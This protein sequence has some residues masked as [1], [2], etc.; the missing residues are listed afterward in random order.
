[1]RKPF[2]AGN[3][4]M[5]TDLKTAAALSEELA[6]GLTGISKVD[7]AICPPFTNLYY[8]KEIIGGSSVKLGA[9]NIFWENSG[10][11]T[12]EISPDMLVA[13]G[14]EYVIIG[15]SERRKYFN[16]TDE[17]VNKKIKAAIVHGLFPIVCVGESLEEREKNETLNII[18]KQLEGGVLPLC[19]HC[20]AVP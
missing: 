2:I 8:V 4:K 13:V 14:C 11:F 6:A 12:G 3:W 17:T 15:H 7:V 20:P 19:A 5:N 10:A 9:Q 18:K 16:E 1:M